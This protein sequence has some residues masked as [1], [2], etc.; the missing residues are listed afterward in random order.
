MFAIAYDFDTEKLKENYHL[1]SYNNAYADVRKFMEG[2]GF[3]AKQG[4]V[5][6]GNETVTMVT[7]VLAVSELSTKFPWVLPSLKDIR[8]LRILDSDDLMPAI[9]S[10]ASK[11]EAVQP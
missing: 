9:Q 1:D 4:S 6:Y 10:G 3:A 8:I 11:A 2:K 5:L 7:A